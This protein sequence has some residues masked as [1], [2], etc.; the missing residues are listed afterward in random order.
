MKHLLYAAAGLAAL[1]F[2]PTGAKA[3]DA[4]W[5]CQILL[6]AASQ[7]PSWQGV[8]Y[9]VP[10]MKKL[11]TEMA[12]PGFDWPICREAKAGEPGRQEFEDCPAGSRPTSSSD[13]DDSG[14]RRTE[15]DQC[16]RI[17]DRCENRGEINRLYGKGDNQRNGVTVR[18]IG[19]NSD[20]YGN[21][22]NRGCKVQVT[23][24]RPR[25][26][27]PWFFDIPNDKGVKERVWFNLRT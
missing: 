26:A 10:P 8:P 16:V 23:S 4:S 12:K 27:N 21:R 22:A 2:A 9:C 11:I 24:P 18:T 5:G 20:N 3:Q 17:V 14:F 1:A 6:C 7:N 15:E 19:S 13:G 25:R